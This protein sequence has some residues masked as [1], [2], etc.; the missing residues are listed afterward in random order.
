MT[1]ISSISGLRGTIGGQPGN[2][3]TP[4]DVVKFTTAFAE[5]LKKANQEKISIVVG[6]DARIS[7][8][9]LKNQVIS[10]LQF[11]GVDVIDID[12]A[13]T[14]T[15]EMI[16]LA[17]KAQGGIILTASHNPKEWN[18]LKFVNSLG[19]FISAELGKKI[20]ELAQA[21]NF[22]FAE[23]NNLGNVENYSEALNYHVEQILNL[24]LVNPNL[25]KQA[26]FTIAVDGINSVGA[27]AI[28]YLLKK[29]GVENIITINDT[30][31][32]NFAHNPEPL[33]EHLTAIS[34]TIVTQKADLGIVVDP[35]VDRLAFVDEQ[36][37]MFG[38]EYT[39][40][41]VADYVLQ[42]E[43][44]APYKKATVSN[45]SSSMALNDLTKKYQGEYQ[46]AAVGEVNVVNKIKSISAVIGGEGNGG[47]IY[48]ELHYG[49]DALVGTALFLTYLAQEKSTVSQLRKKYPDYTMIKHKITL[50][51]KNEIKPT[52][53]KLA[54]IYKDENLDK[55]DGLKIIFSDSWVH[56]RPSNTE[57]IMR[58][59]I[60]APNQSQADKLLQEILNQLQ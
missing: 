59:Y 29:L 44:K 4:I 15:V 46:A 47:V 51:D 39:L 11:C 21:E 3:L 52:L 40:V 2:N 23:I 24:P 12:L 42:N 8:L 35:D 13:T 32:G 31:D 6:R 41:A 36:G 17:K 1:L 7:G 20:L 50:A 58:L 43:I 22:N 14:P 18:A 27:I 25:I 28:P 5:V 45:L 57:A 19:E 56:I 26:N 49:R 10:T 48:P 9:A 37:K 60:E 34:Q 33:P 38:E 30:P 16:V 54:D 53:E 55:Q